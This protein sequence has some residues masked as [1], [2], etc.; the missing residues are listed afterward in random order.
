MMKNNK[1]RIIEKVIDYVY[2]D[3]IDGLSLQEVI[4]LFKGYRQDTNVDVRCFVG[5]GNDCLIIKSSHIE[6]EEEYIQRIKQEEITKQNKIQERFRLYKELRYEFDDEYRE[7]V[8]KENEFKQIYQ[9]RVGEELIELARNE[10][11][12]YLDEYEKESDVC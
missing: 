10:Q 8:D 1:Q 4:E 11:Y 2:V 3:D 12:S 5:E 9:S 7:S 6:T